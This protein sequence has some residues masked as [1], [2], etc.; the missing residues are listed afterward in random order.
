MFE[1]L[2]Q[3][4][5][6][7]SIRSFEAPLPVESDDPRAGPTGHTGL[8]AQA[9]GPAPPLL[10][11]HQKGGDCGWLEVAAEKG[12]GWEVG[13]VRAEL[14][15]LIEKY[16]DEPK[17]P[18]HVYIGPLLGEGR[19]E[20]CRAGR[21]ECAGGVP[22]RLPATVRLPVLPVLPTGPRRAAFS[23]PFLL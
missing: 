8:Q 6:D 4:G 17:A 19:R 22:A 18:A 1:Y 3:K 15:A 9:L 7:A 14:A 16:K 12:F 10:L 20:G 11:P 2:L 5:A 21:R 13:A 23:P